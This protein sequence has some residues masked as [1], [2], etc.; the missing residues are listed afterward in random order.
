LGAFRETYCHVAWI[1]GAIDLRR[2]RL[3]KNPVSGELAT[4]TL[5]FERS[6]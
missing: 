6:K 4:S 3:I 2:A 5:V 1:G